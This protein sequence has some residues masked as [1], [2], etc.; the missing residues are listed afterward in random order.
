MAAPINI[1]ANLNLNPSSINA[2][3]KQV[4]QALGRITGQASEFQ[5]SLDASTARVFAFGATTSIINGINQSFKKLIGTTITVQAKLTE[6]N[7]ILGAGAAEFNAY[8][9]SIFK[10]AKTTGQSFQTVADGAAELAR[11][12]LGAAESAKRLEAA[13][14]LTR[15]SGLGAQ[16]SVKALTAAMNGFTSA[17][18]TAEQVVNKIVAVDT[19]FAVSAQDLAD[20]FSRAGSTAE[21]AGVSFDELLGL[22]TAV[23]QRTAR[24]GAVIG[25]AFKSIFT[26]LSRGS[27]I[28]DLKA[29]GVEIDANQTGVQKL[30]ALSKALEQVADPTVASQI[31]E[32]AGGVF[33]I[34]VVSAALKDLGSDASIFARA[35]ETGLNATNEATKKNTELNKTL[36]AQINSLTASITS[37]AEKLGSITFGPLLE[38]LVSLA[39]TLSEG[40]D[41][42]LDPEKGNKFI[43]GIF[44]VI[45]NFISG[46]GLAIFSIAFVKIF[47]TVIKFAKDGFKAVMEI[48]SA[49]ERIKQ[50][51]G[52]LIG[53]LQKDEDLRNKLL[54]TTVTQ[55]EKEQAVISAIQ[56][57]NQLLAQQEALVTNIS[58]IARKKG[59]SGFDS[60]SGSFKGKRGKRFAAGGAG[61][62]EPNL[63]TAMM[64]EARDAPRGALPYVTNFRGSP[65]V[66][67]T[68][69]MQVKIG[70]REEILTADQIPRFNKGSGRTRP[71]KGKKGGAEGT[72]VVNNKELGDRFVF[73]TPEVDERSSFGPMTVDKKKH[74][75]THQIHGIKSSQIQSVSDKEED[76]LESKV[77]NSLFKEAADWT[78]RIKPLD[79]SAPVSEIAKGFD[80]IRGAKGA[81]QGAIGSAFEVGI[82][83][84][85]KYE[86]RERD[87][88]GD[89]D[90]RGGPNIS[91]IQKLF[92]IRQTIGD[93][94]SSSS[95]GN[96]RS[97]VRKVRREKGAGAFTQKEVDRQ[98]ANEYQRKGTPLVVA[99][100]KALSARRAS[101]KP[102]P[103]KAKGTI[104][105]ARL[106]AR[107]G[108]RRFAGGSQPKSLADVQEAGETRQ[109]IV[110]DSSTVQ[111][112]IKKIVEGFQKAGAEAAKSGKEAGQSFADMRA[113]AE[114]KAQKLKDLAGKYKLNVK[115]VIDSAKA[116]K[117]RSGAIKAG[118]KAL[119]KQ[120]KASLKSGIKSAGALGAGFALSAIGTGIESLGTDEEGNEVDTGLGKAAR[121]AGKA[122]SFAAT[123]AML[124]GPIGAAIGGVI[125]AGMGIYE[126]RKKSKEKEAAEQEQERALK[127]RRKV[128][129]IMQTS[130][131][132][133][134]VDSQANQL[135]NLSFRT[136]DSSLDISAELERARNQLNKSAESGEGFF[137]AQQAFAAVSD[138]V[139]KLLGEKDGIQ[140]LYEEGVKIKSELKS[141]LSENAGAALKK[142]LAGGQDQ[143]DTR[144]ALL[145]QMV[146]TDP[147]SQARIDQLNRKNQIDSQILKTTGEKAN[148]LDLRAQLAGA[149]DPTQRA[150]LAKKLQEAGKAFDA[151][152]RQSANFLVSKQMEISRMLA[153]GAKERMNL[154]RNVLTGAFADITKSVKEGP[155]DL[156]AVAQY[157]DDFKAAK[158]DDERREILASFQDNVLSKFSGNEKMQDFLSEIAGFKANSETDK[159]N[160]VT[161]KEEIERIRS[162]GMSTGRTRS[163]RDRF[164]SLSKGGVANQALSAFNERMNALQTEFDAVSTSIEKFSKDFDAGPV[165]SSIQM[166]ADKLNKFAFNTGGVPKASEKLVDISKTAMGLAT[167][168]ETAIKSQETRLEELT[169]R[170]AK[171]EADKNVIKEGASGS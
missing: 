17:G 169:S 6:I 113:A 49:A 71:Y 86:A 19:A 115:A 167:K 122:T 105:N 46:P 25:N 43:Q 74:P 163:D 82:S 116:E 147:A 15:I 106:A 41:N 55:A 84:S 95:D 18:L 30:Q 153:E 123:G 87:A 138:R 76:S 1:N 127:S 140:A 32:L 79:K 94:K 47:K 13:L 9:N 119:L 37:F 78:S 58:R 133:G 150:E 120:S 90:V 81:L 151:S 154:E 85:L 135:K 66:M 155:M 136:G 162:E 131:K 54:S 63:M 16:Q 142:E 33:Q 101:K 26:R 65:A 168:A 14:I 146:G 64:N 149:T 75:A 36:L 20:G 99:R 104:S 114:E 11:Q 61:E 134:N 62:M 109:K 70:G 110:L 4:Q 8:R 158:T 159:S 69:E 29:L 132:F 117:K 10:V 77:K 52:G 28:E 170:L 56:R 31:K 171:V 126:E 23:E 98:A 38:N 161:S 130:G 39:T 118:T 93:F 53:L 143:V 5:K 124:G 148:Q 139:A 128:S 44:K 83:K 102:V 107:T 112:E 125:G 88:G 156:D 166:T 89:F 27:T 45:G 7:S 48:G 144:S 100:R 103:A 22:I 50:I 141:L 24:G 145:G 67:N 42:A 160:M 91:R 2:S 73:L 12:G 34:N 129:E 152:V 21:D 121:V 57:E 51:E 40:L 68:S 164:A 35:T 157:G 111:G 60:S 80:S 108:I 72:Q 137:E 97:F 96:K 59:V 165:V 3:A 92:G